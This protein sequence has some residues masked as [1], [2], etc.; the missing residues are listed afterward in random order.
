M[1][2]SEAPILAT[3]EPIGIVISHGYGDDAPAMF[4]Y[5]YCDAPETTDEPLAVAAA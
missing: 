3:D 2:K 4:A 5:A 1:K